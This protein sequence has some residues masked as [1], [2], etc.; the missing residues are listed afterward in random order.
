MSTHNGMA[1]V[2]LRV[3]GIQHTVRAA[4][5]EHE[6]RIDRD[7]QLAIE[8]CCSADN[9]RAVVEEQVSR[10]F[11]EVLTASIKSFFAYGDGREAIDAAVRSSLDFVVS[12]LSA[13][14]RSDS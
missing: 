13:A 9:I 5:M 12:G 8:R 1:I 7:I 6:A 4:L 3:H 10:A 11:N 14:K 2:E